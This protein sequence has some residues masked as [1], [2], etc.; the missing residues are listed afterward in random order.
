LAQSITGRERRALMP[1]LTKMLNDEIRRLARK[2][3][4]AA[5]ATTQKANQALKKSVADLKKRVAQLEKEKKALSTRIK[6]T[7]EAIPSTPIEE[8]SAR[9]TAKGVR[10]LRRKWKFTREEFAKVVGV[11]PQAIYQWESKDGPLSLRKGPK[12]TYLAVR[13][14][15]AR[16]VRAKLEGMGVSRNQRGK[17]KK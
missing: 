4:K 12:A 8:R 10:S 14:M 15:G 11:S 1:N 6:R 5:L 3:A 16:E 9:I 17:G 7:A 2:E 13:D